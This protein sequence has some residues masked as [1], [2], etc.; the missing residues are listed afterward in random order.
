MKKALAQAVLLL[1]ILLPG[2]VFASH[3]TPEGFVTDTAG[4]ISGGVKASLINELTD[5][6]TQTGHEVAVVTVPSLQGDYIE[7]YA[8]TLF[9]EW[10]IGR[11]GEDDGVLFLIS[12]DDR[13][14]RIEV[15]YGLEGDL[16]DAQSALIINS[17][18]A[19]RFKEGNF[20]QGIRDGVD[21]IARSIKGEPLPETISQKP[22]AASE[23]WGAAPGFVFWF[24][25][26]L[27]MYLASILGRSKSWWMGGVLG[28]V[29]GLIICAVKGISGT[30]LI[31]TAMFVLAGLMFDFIVSRG[32]RSGIGSG[33]IPP[34]WAGG[35]G[36][37]G[38]FGGFGG[39]RSG[40]GGA[41]GSW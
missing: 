12:R 29:F 37:G 2:A 14:M 25:P 32:Y 13:Q 4:M 35:G 39:G 16:T 21:A 24:F 31:F 26:F 10:G 28:G 15:G 17:I 41:S 7:H 18:V 22:F 8:V 3:P 36:I 38:G 9:Q 40:G 1:L 34:W 33:G 30:T 27:A 6:K 20:E 11:K 5:L 23:L 19:P